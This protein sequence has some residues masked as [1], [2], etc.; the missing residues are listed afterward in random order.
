LQSS[1]SGGF[2]I[3]SQDEKLTLA[4]SLQ[5]DHAPILTLQIDPSQVNEWL[6]A[7]EQQESGQPE[8]PEILIKAF[9][10]MVKDGQSCARFSAHR[11]AGIC[12]C[13]GQEQLRARANPAQ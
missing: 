12:Y 8:R 10:C 11:L 4:W 13:L 9:L 3:C 1:R 6:L 7:G 5:R 2:L